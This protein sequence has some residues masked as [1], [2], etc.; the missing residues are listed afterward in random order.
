MQE[1]AAAAVQF[2][3]G[4]FV[5]PNTKSSV[6]LKACQPLAFIHWPLQL[7]SCPSCGQEHALQLTEVQHPP[8]YGY[9]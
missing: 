5:C 3:V 9:E 8:V 2:V 6:P 4:R 1:K 7:E